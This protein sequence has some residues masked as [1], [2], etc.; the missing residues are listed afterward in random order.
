MENAATPLE[1]M[2]REIRHE[3][4][5]VKYAEELLGQ[6]RTSRANVDRARTVEIK[7]KAHDDWMLRYGRCL[8]ALTTLVHCRKLSAEAYNTFNIEV[9]Q[10]AASTIVGQIIV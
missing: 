2:F 7:L 1:Q 6:L 5:A 8:G 9:R 10:T 3:E 4:D